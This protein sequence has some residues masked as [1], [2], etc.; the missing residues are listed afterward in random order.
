MNK[1][2]K[3]IG[4]ITASAVLLSI[5]WNIAD[6][7]KS[8]TVAAAAAHVTASNAVLVNVAKVKTASIPKEVTALGSLSAVQKV[9][10][11]AQT[12]GMVAKIY[13][14]NG[15]DVGK[16]MP[17]LQQDNTQANADYQ[18]A[19]TDLKLSRKTY[20][21]DL[22]VPDALSQQ[23]MEEAEADVTSKESD[24]KNKL[25]ALNQKQIIAPFDG[26]LGDIKANE[27]GRA[28]V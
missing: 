13:F 7:E 21:R 10:L 8:A 22:K 25:A 3:I 20:Q 23:A 17:V 14:K 5:C 28:H 1:S 6:G 2:S 18:T 11:S 27:I 9:T 12:D 16:G 19:V 24:V 26:V 15:Q 4:L